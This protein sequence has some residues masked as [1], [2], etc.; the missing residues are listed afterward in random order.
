MNIADVENDLAARIEGEKRE[1][2]FMRKRQKEC[3]ERIENCKKNI[4]E[5]MVAL[6]IVK[7]GQDYQARANEVGAAVMVDAD[8]AVDAHAAE[9]DKKQTIECFCQHWETTKTLPTSVFTLTCKRCGRVY[10]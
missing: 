5:S 2:D 4:A 8:H 7:I 6:R 3:E 9:P 1:I 10:A